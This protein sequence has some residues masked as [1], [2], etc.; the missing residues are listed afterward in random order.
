MI[1]VYP[2]LPI[3]VLAP[4]NSAV[5]QIASAV[6]TGPAALPLRQQQLI[7]LGNETTLA[8]DDVLSAIFQPARAQRLEGIDLKYKLWVDKLQNVQTHDEEDMMEVQPN[9]IQVIKT[10][11]LD[12]PMNCMSDIKSAEKALLLLDE[13]KDK[14]DNS[15]LVLAG[16]S[17]TKCKVKVP[18]ESKSLDGV[19]IVFST[20]NGAMKPEVQK[21]MEGALVI[22]DEGKPLQS[23]KKNAFAIQR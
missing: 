6:F 11:T 12:L 23:F 13:W 19:Q 21:F 8:T 16:Q 17:A 20:L 9:A 18:A 4:S 1:K 10:V 2:T 14:K 7:L 5:R 22:I 3:V 15:L